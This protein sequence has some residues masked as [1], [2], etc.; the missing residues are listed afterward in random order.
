MAT[1]VDTAAISLGLGVAEIGV[2]DSN[3]VFT[4]YTDLGAIKTAVELN[5]DQT[6]Q[7][8]DS[9]RP[10]QTLKREIVQQK[11]TVK[12]TLAEIKVATLKRMLGNGT[13]TSSTT[14]TFLDGT[15]I[16][17]TGDLSSSVT[18]VTLGDKF[19]S[20]GLCDLENVGIRF[21]HLLSCSTGKRG[22]LEVYK[23]QATGRLTLPFKETDWSLVDAE[24]GCLADTN[25]AA[26]KQVF[27]YFIER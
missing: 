13:I 14:T 12:F 7:D 25:R 9:G 18:A 22:I 15:S 27:Q 19:E 1:R 2:F 6:I 4:A 23:A 24:W 11:T 10:L 16:A 21:T 20:G 26:G 5:I 3:F 8:F 17:P